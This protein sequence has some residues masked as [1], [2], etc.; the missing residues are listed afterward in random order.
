MIGSQIRLGGLLYPYYTIVGFLSATALLID[1]PWAGP[2]VTNFSYQILQV[3]YPVPS[4]FVYWYIVTSPKDG[5][6]LW[7]N[8]TEND[9]ALLTRNVPTKV[10]LTRLF[11]TTTLRSLAGSSDLLFRLRL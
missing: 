4:D 9:L 3:Y 10:R 11:S 5:Y 7:T 6:R 8:I 2:D 1:Q